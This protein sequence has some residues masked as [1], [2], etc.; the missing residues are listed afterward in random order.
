MYRN[1]FE[2][3]KNRTVEQNGCWIWTGPKVGSLGYGKVGFHGKT[4]RAHRVMWELINGPIP[5]GLLVCH[6]CDHAACINPEHLFLGTPTEN[7]HDMA[8]KGRSATGERNAHRLYPERYPKGD[9]HYS[10]TNPEKLARGEHHGMSKLTVEKVKFIRANYREI[11]IRNLTK[12]FDVTK[13]AI[14]A[15]YTNKTWKGF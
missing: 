2:R 7:N 13:S 8:K 15:V 12:M 9:S 6:K 5:E 14:W 4:A 10:R 1:N 3:L 11:G